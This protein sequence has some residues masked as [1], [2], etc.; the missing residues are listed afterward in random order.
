[1]GNIMKTVIPASAAFL[2]QFIY[3]TETSRKAPGC[4]LTIYGHNDHLLKTPITSM[5]IDQI[6]SNQS[7]WSKA[8]GSSA[9]G[10]AQFM[11]ATLQ[12]LKAELK[13]SGS[14]KFDGD[15]QD[16]LAYHLLKRR[17]YDAFMA[18][19]IDVVEFAKRLAME[20]A[21]FPVLENCRGAH[22]ML[23]RG[24]SYYAGDGLNK[25]LVK[26]E[27]VE[28]VL[29]QVYAM[30]N[31]TVVSIPDAPVRIPTKPSTKSTFTAST[32]MAAGIIF[33]GTFWTWLSD[34]ACAL[35]V[36]NLFCGG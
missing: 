11:K 5:T 24:Q 17:G 20:W 7:A 14:Q 34:T 31:P 19:K 1:M 6:L 8:F 25:S 9:T 26:P 30:R 29:A 22:R 23:K 21:S 35:D 28:K 32:V 15:L 10:A 2:L 16:R 13:L 12:G 36:F 33:V 3:E 18:G 27:L 4:Y